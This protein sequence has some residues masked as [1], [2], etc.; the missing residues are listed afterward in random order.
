[1]KTEKEIIRKRVTEAWEILC[2]YRKVFGIGHDITNR[3]RMEWSILDNLW[4][5]LYDEEY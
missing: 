5:E 1:M 3:K 4:N 2:F